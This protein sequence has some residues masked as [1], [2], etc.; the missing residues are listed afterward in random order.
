MG[1]L[2]HNVSRGCS[3]V[4]LLL[5]GSS[6]SSA[7]DGLRSEDSRY[8]GR[9]FWKAGGK[10]GPPSAFKGNDRSEQLGEDTGA[11]PDI[12][13]ISA[14]MNLPIGRVDTTVTQ[15][16]SLRSKSQDIQKREL[17]DNVISSTD[18]AGIKAN[19]SMDSV[20]STLQ[21]MFHSLLL[22]LE[23][24]QWSSNFDLGKT[25]G[26]KCLGAVLCNSDSV[27]FL[28][29]KDLFREICYALAV[30]RQK[31]TGILFIWAKTRPLASA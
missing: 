24:L 10:D 19:I 8:W 30:N 27:P 11:I 3:L 2:A 15:D 6:P 31:T 5:L 17:G 16:S 21:L 13:D 4:L 18:A 1:P 29:F 26:R 22:M 14:R 9:G 12:P 25:D 23:R 28:V 20:M 7:L